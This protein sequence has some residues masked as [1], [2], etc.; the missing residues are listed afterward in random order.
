MCIHGFH[1]PERR[2]MKKR[3]DTQQDLKTKPV[4]EWI[5]LIVWPMAI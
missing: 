5:N 4:K 2:L 1:L 3:P